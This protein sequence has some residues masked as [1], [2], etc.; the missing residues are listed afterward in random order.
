MIHFPSQVVG[1]E[2][3]SLELEDET[4]SGEAFETIYSLLDHLSPSYRASFH[5]ALSDKLVQLE[6]Y[7]C[8]CVCDSP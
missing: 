4:E 6:V 5:H 8:V 1:R 2:Y 7:V 3:D